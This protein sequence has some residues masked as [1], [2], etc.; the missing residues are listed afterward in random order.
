MLNSYPIFTPIINGQERANEQP[1]SSCEWL[2][3]NGIG[4]FASGTVSCALTRRYHGLLIAALNPPLGR[5]LIFPKVE[6]I[7]HYQGKQFSLTTN[8][9]VSGEIKPQGYQLIERFH[10]DGKIPVWTYDLGATKIRK[11]IWMPPGKNTTCVQ[12]Q[13]L[14]VEPASLDLQIDILSNFRD[15]HSITRANH[16]KEFT[17][18]RINNGLRI[19]PPG[20]SLPYFFYCTKG[21]ISLVN[22]WQTGYFLMQE[23]FRGEQAVEDHLLAGQLLASLGAGE[24]LTL[25]FSIEEKPGYQFELSWS[26]TK[27]HEEE[28]WQ[29]AQKSL[30]LD[31][32]DH[33]TLRQLVL[34][35]D[36]FIV[37]RPTA[38]DPDGKTIIA[39]YHWFSDWGRDTMISLPGLTL[40]AG[41][42]EIAKKILQT[43]A[44]YLDQGM[45]P[46]RFPDIGETPEYNTVD[47]TLWY[48]EALRNYISETNDTDLLRHI[49][50]KLLDIIDWHFKGTRYNIHVDPA[51][52]LLFSGEAG[53][54]LTWMDV[55]IDDWVVTPR[56]GKP[57]EI[58]ALWYNA[59][60]CME[61]FSHLLGLDTDFFSQAAQKALNSFQKF[62]DYQNHCLFDVIDGPQGVEKEIRPNQI[63]A[64]SLNFSPLTLHQARA[65]VDCCA[66][67]LLTPYGLRSLA[68]HEAN[69]K[70]FYSGDRATRDAA[71]HQGTVWSW[72]L[73]PFISAHLRVYQ[74]V[75]SA[76]NYLR[77]LLQ[78]LDEYGLGTIGE[79]ADG[80]FPH[81]PQGC[82]SQAWSVAEV[83]RVICQI[84][85]L[86]SH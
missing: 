52:G 50:P 23:D 44:N 74:D 1:A 53:V 5:T 12:Y 83:L 57:V 63:F 66:R 73:G 68:A 36:Q 8:H 67:Y 26:S 84:G 24:K 48:F 76:I 31:I 78:Q 41:R 65:I 49:Y 56:M 72:L 42:P 17:V 77:P 10:L 40:A 39:G 43:F 38:E 86:D 6:E 22:Q 55:K 71:Y 35:A 58:N 70:P 62:W 75:E 3:T 60:C 18:D 61:Y 33:E 29:F 81:K 11:L 19:Q 21:D 30:P 37:N 4:G 34:A 27:Q 46:N 59:L 79:I 28:I 45:L 54:Q 25:I 82:I 47:A 32:I 2:I 14:S 16:G 7:I 51:D 80:D 20:E 15:Y 9:W 13:H 64:V 69:Y 85:S